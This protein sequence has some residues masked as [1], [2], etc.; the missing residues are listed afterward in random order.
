MFRLLTLILSFAFKKYDKFLKN[1][2]FKFFWMSKIELCTNLIEYLNLY[3]NKKII[4]LFK[5]N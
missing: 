3:F 2:N 4:L 5:Q 1:E